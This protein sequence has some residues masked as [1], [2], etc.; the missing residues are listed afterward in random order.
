M[1]IKIMQDSFNIWFIDKGIW[2]ILIGIAGIIGVWVISYLIFKGLKLLGADPDRI[3]DPNSQKLVNNIKNIFVILVAFVVAGI[4]SFFGILSVLNIG[5]SDAGLDWAIGASYQLIVSNGIPILIVI[6][7]AYISL[8]I[9]GTIMPNLIKLYLNTGTRVG[10]HSSENEKRVE[11]FAIV[12]RSV[13]RIFVVLIA[14]L[15]IL[16][17]LGVPVTSLVAGISIL[18]IAVG[19]G[20]QSLVKDVIQGML[21][22]AENQLRKGDIV[23]IKGRA[24]L[25]EDLNLRRILI[26]DLDG[27]LHIIPNGSTDII[28]NLTSQWSRVN[29][30][31]NVSY[32]EDLEKAIKTLN[33]IG[34]KVD[35]D[36]NIGRFIKEKPRVWTITSFSDSGVRLKF[37]GVTQPGKQWEVRTQVIREIKIAFDDEGIKIP[38]N[39][40]RVIN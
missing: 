33:N 17:I 7:L 24:G 40:I 29:I 13:L 10:E 12:I 15:T 2:L 38:Y 16:S 22:I 9:A 39:Q 35:N 1:L 4:P 19:L 25:V 20:S 11:T 8:R 18:G 3:S 32:E 31:I 6:I 5:E 26:R 37:V 30:E 34:D 14:V 36:Q 28:T 23:R 21:I 27:A